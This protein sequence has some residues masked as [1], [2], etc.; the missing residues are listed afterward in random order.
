MFYLMGFNI[1]FVLCSVVMF[2]GWC[3][4][5]DSFYTAY[6]KLIL[7]VIF[8]PDAFLSW[9]WVASEIDSRANINEI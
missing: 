3:L 2:F 9:V 5:L 8:L 7:F 6:K 4:P 1:I